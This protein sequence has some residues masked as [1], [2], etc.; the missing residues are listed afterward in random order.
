MPG[1]ISRIPAKKKQNI[2]SK[3]GVMVLPSFKFWPMPRHSRF[4]MKM[5]KRLEAIWMRNNG[6]NP[7]QK[8]SKM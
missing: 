2:S 8:K 7:I 6:Q 4:T 1:M 5:P 3:Y